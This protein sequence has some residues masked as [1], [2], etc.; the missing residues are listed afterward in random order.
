MREPH[1]TF[2]TFIHHLIKCILQEN[3][4][5]MNNFESAFS[6][7][8]NTIQNN[9]NYNYVTSMDADTIIITVHNRPSSTQV[10]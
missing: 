9:I 7:K 5:I 4:G 1:Q 2:V 3:I 6:S 8:K 10:G